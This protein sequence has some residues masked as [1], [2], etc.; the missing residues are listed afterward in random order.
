MNREERKAVISFDTA[1]DQQLSAAMSIVA[2][3][4]MSIMSVP[5]L[6]QDE[7]YGIVYVDTSDL[8]SPF[9][10]DDLQLLNS[11]ASQVA[12]FIKN[13]R[14]VSN[15]E[16]E[17]ELRTN[18]GRYLSPG[19]V[20]E[21][22]SG[23]LIPS[24]GG[25]SREG[26]CLFSDIVGF[27]RICRT[28][29]AAEVVG[30]LNR[31][32]R[33]AVDAVFT[34][35]GTVDKFGGDAMLCVW[36]APV[37]MEDHASPAI[38]S[39]L[40]MQ[41]RLYGFGLDLAKTSDV[42][43]RMGIGLNSGSF[44]AGNVGSEERLEY[45]VIGDN[46]NLAQRCEEKATGGQVLINS[47]TRDIARGCAAIKLQTTIIRGAIGEVTVHSVRGIRIS[48]MPESSLLLSIPCMAGPPEGPAD[49]AAILTALHAR[50]EGNVLVLRYPTSS[51]LD[52]HPALQIEP[53]LPEVPS[54]PSLGG[55]VLKVMPQDEE[56]PWREVELLVPHLP[57]PLDEILQ[58][59]STW[60]SPLS[61]DEIPRA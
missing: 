49:V 61:P 55:G 20:S 47:S 56:R 1:S 23:N 57:A 43:I 19:V 31:F 2:A 42:K 11:M 5:I 33:E 21:I 29:T 51:N 26:T 50:P 13:A 34:F 45:T 9:E 15:I 14:L 4:I 6:Q 30:L 7:F 10:S 37:A 52:A 16:Q 53:L 12:I 25:E 54:V 8:A 32:F 28:M 58:P 24:L 22:A 46:V 48:T 3:G 60:E 59:D 36:G 35:D 44:I 18:L 38:A 40:E 27:T 39:A 41:N 17:T